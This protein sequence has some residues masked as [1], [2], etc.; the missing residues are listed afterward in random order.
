MARLLLFLIPLLLVSCVAP[1]DYN[2]SLIRE[3]RRVLSAIN[4]LNTVIKQA[5]KEETNSELAEAVN[6][7][8]K[9]ILKVQQ[10][11]LLE[12]K[13]S[14]ERKWRSCLFFISLF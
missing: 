5:N 8:E 1:A 11:M 2:D 7:V 12:G 3:Q 6:Q 9:S 13:H 10:K 4:D 14:C